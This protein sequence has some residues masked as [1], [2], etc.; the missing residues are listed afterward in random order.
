MEP[1]SARAGLVNI[2]GE[3]LLAGFAVG[4]YD[5]VAP[6]GW[7]NMLNL[8][9]FG[10]DY[11]TRAFIAYTGLGALPR[12]D[13]VYPSAFVDETGAALDGG[14]RYVMHFEKG[15]LPPSKVGVWSISPYRDNFYVRNDLDCYGIRSSMPLTFNADGSLDIYIQATSPGGDKE[16][17][18]LPCPPSGSFNLTIRAYQ[19]MESLL[20]G[21]YVPPP[22]R[23][24][25]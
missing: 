10:T 8:G 19:P 17:N 1:V 25:S 9:R 4:P 20:D 14:A 18:W 24:V 12:E 21:T 13:A 7:I 16:S 2:S 3:A 15:A 22:V 23:R 11:N 5:M 6:N